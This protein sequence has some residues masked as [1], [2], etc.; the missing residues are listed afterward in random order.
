MASQPIHLS[1]ANGVT[2]G[3][4]TGSNFSVLTASVAGGPGGAAQTFSAGTVSGAPNPIHLANSNGVSFGL[5]TGV[6]SSVVTATVATNYQSQGAYLTTA[7]LSD[8]VHP[9]YLTTAQPPGAYLTT[10]AQSNHTHD[11]LTTAAQS[12]HSHGN[13]TLALTNLTG[14]TASN[15]AGLTLSLSAAAPGGGAAFNRSYFEIMD[16][17]QLTTAAQASAASMS[18][19]PILVPFWLDGNSLALNTVRIMISRTAGTSLNATLGC[20]FYSLNN[21]TQLGLHASTTHAVSLTTSAQWSGVRAFDFTGM[22]ASSLNEGRWVMALYV[23]GSNNSTAVA[24]FGFVGGGA[25]PVSGWIYPGTNS[26]GATASNSRFFPFWGVY[27]N[28]T[29]AFPATI[30]ATDVMGGNSGHMADIYA[31]ILEVNP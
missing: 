24:N 10:A 14:T 12:N 18:K 15:S 7:A 28:T 16:G 13:P 30:A 11:Y 31:A 21:E 4:G 2:W 20:A 26:T 6:N 9:A 27:S 19:R 8:H 29:A 17:E 22:G 25:I 23:S 5:G 3:F 1:D